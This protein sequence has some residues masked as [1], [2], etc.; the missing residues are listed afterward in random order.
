MKPGG[1]VNLKKINGLDFL[2]K[3]KLL[4]LMCLSFVIGVIVSTLYFSGGTRAAVISEKLFGNYMYDRQH[5]GFAAIMFSVMLKYFI[6]CLSFF[7]LGTSVIGV[8]LAPVTCCG[9][10][11]YFGTLASYSYSAFSL[12]GIAFNSVILIPPALI[13]IFCAFFAAKEAFEFSSVLLKL[14]L[15]K[16]RPLNVSENFKLYCGKFLIVLALMTA[17]ALVDAVVSVSFLDYFNI[18]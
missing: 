16:S 7:V 4:I 15:P 9:L 8:V 11:L 5:G 2:V 10:G 3:N 17:A 14:T 1:V 12:K 13:F 18:L 6:V